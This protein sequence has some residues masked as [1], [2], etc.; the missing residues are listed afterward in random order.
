MF[1]VITAVH[2]ISLDFCPSTPLHPMPS[3]E[4]QHPGRPS[5]EGQLDLGRV[6]RELP[7][8]GLGWLAE[9]IISE[10]PRN[11]VPRKIFM[12]SRKI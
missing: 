5:A 4:P 9:S 12:K 8:H 10:E 11:R 1:I 7:D 3:P 2:I 6:G